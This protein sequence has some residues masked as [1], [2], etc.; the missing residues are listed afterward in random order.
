MSDF[1]IRE[2]MA[3]GGVVGK[4]TETENAFVAAFLK[5]S[6]FFGGE[7][8]EDLDFYGGVA[9]E[10]MS[11]A[12]GGVMGSVMVDYLVRP[13]GALGLL[14]GVGIAFGSAMEDK[15]ETGR[16]AAAKVHLGADVPLLSD[17]G[18]QIFQLSFTPDFAVTANNDGIGY[19]FSAGLGF[20]FDALG[21]VLKAF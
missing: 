8:T 6:V 21:L 10:V 5:T 4:Q 1:Q 7:L 16:T 20:D 19:S 17:D 3:G 2:R 13:S 11:P 14:V 12:S 9:G 15:Q 18:G